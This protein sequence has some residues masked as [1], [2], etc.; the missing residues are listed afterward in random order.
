[1]Y[2]YNYKGLILNSFIIGNFR[3]TETY[4]S[5]D[6]KLIK[7]AHSNAILSLVENGYFKENISNESI[8]IKSFD[9]LYKP[10]L[11]K[12]SNF[13]SSGVKCLNIEIPQ[14]FINKAEKMGLNMKNFFFIKSSNNAN[15]LTR[16]KKELKKNNSFSVKVL[17]G[18][19]YEIL[20]IKYLMDQNS[21]MN[22]PVWL[23]KL[24]NNIESSNCNL[25]LNDLSQMANKHPVYIINT[26]N[27]YLNTTPSEYIRQLKYKLICKELINS[28][29]P[30][31]NIVYQ[32]NFFDES[33]FFKFFKKYSGKT[34]TSF[35]QI[36]KN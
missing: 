6:S 15:L 30:L 19:L 10:P 9:I 3:I 27:K 20:E 4:Y 2:D 11:T 18:I 36:H 25:S 29:K 24:L 12:H 35:R 22:R 21:K 17:E 1:M 14:Y 7:H 34:P 8:Q 26:F 23:I 16:L 5:K 33:H 32:F 31:I 28:D 13:F